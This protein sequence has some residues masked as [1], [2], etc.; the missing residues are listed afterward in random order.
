MRHPDDAGGA[1]VD[2]LEQEARLDAECSATVVTLSG[3]RMND[4]TASPST[5][6]HGRPASASAF[7]PAS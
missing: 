3:G 6:D 4:V 1:A 2:A 7:E 5:T